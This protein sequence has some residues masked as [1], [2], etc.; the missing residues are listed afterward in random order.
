MKGLA[1]GIIVLGVILLDA[2][3]SRA[4]GPDVIVSNLLGDND[5]RLLSSGYQDPHGDGNLVSAFSVGTVSCNIGNQDLDWNPATNQH[6]VIGQG[7]YRLKDNRFEQIGMSWVKHGFYALNQSACGVPCTNSN[8]GYTLYVG[9]SDP[10]E[11][12][13]NSQRPFLGPT[14]E[15]NAH[16][17]AF[18]SPHLPAASGSS[19][20]A[21]RLQIHN[22][23]LDPSLNAGALYFV[24]GHY[25]HPDDAFS[26]NGNNNASYRRVVFI[27]PTADPDRYDGYV[28]DTTQKLQC[29]IR[30]WKDNDTSVVETDAQVPNEG[31]FILSAKVTN[32]GTGFFHYEYALQNLNSDRSGGSFTV[33]L[34]QGVFIENI[35]FHDVDYHSGDGSTC[36]GC[37]CSGGSNHGQPCNRNSNCPGAG[38][39]C[40]GQHLN[41]DGTDW[42]ATVEV[43]SITWRTTPYDQ[44]PAAN[45]LRW[46][47][48]YNF[49]FDANVEPDPDGT[50]ATLGLFKPGFPSEIAIHTVGPKEGLIDCNNN[51]VPDAC[52]L[53]CEGLG[54]SPPCE[55]SF[56]CNGNRVPDECEADCNGNDIPDNCDVAAGACDDCD[57]NGLPDPVSEDCQPNTV[58][59]ECETDCDGDTIPDTCETITDTDGD[60]V[61]DCDDLC[62]ETT[63]VN[64]CVPPQ[65]VTCCFAS[66]LYIPNYSRASCLALNGTPVCDD[67]IMCPG[68][69][70]PESLCRD[71]CLMGDFDRDGD[72]D[73]FD[74]AALQLCFSS[75]IG[76]SA[77]VSPSPECLLRFDFDDDGDVDLDDTGEF[78]AAY[79]GP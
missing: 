52:D 2:A 23:D 11:A 72:S 60:G 38:A 39:T 53:D 77:F 76:T 35:G 34:P 63:P 24:Q 18:D 31:L 58:P 5:T 9:C 44:N 21:N 47:T 73:L 79:T 25:V 78:F 70:C 20:I 16:T 19:G 8:S 74:A 51:T 6:P 30:A 55:G 48:L 32:L 65:F 26:G 14:W 1:T 57:R 40:F 4:A 22:D 49:R 13:L 54:C 69:P 43:G 12:T 10:Y 61:E 56:D 62:P 37:V 64:A 75:S 7:M 46:S 59:D 66:G 71:G 17:G 41:Y 67:L 33:P 36:P 45:A 3:T 68:T 28:Q 29:A 50:T 15:I 27:R 42:E